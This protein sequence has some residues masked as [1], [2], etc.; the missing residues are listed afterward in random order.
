MRPAISPSTFLNLDCEK[1]V[2]QKKDKWLSLIRITTR[3]SDYPLKNTYELCTAIVIGNTKNFWNFRLAHI[4]IKDKIDAK[5]TSDGV[6]AIV[7]DAL[8][9][10]FCGFSLSTNTIKKE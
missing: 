3:A 5:L 1:Y 6:L 10:Q 8:N 2:L 4:N 9:R 7:A